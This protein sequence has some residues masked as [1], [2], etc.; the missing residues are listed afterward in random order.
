TQ[1]LVLERFDGYWGGAEPWDRVIRKEIPND[2]SRVAQL[3]A[4]QVDIISKVPASDVPVLEQ[5]SSLTVVKNESIYVSYL[6][7]DFREDSPEITA[8]DGAKLDKNPLRDPRVREAIDLA[9]DRE[10]IVD[11]A[12]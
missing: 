2:A 1:D 4:G 3:K 10:T 9:L 7:F 8:K 12:L 6:E 11:Y 5:D